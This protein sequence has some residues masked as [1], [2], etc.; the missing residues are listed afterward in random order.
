MP[1]RI[2]PI[3]PLLV[4]A[5]IVRVGTHQQRRCN[6]PAFFENAEGNMKIMQI[7]NNGPASVLVAVAL[8]RNAW[9]SQQVT[10]HYQNGRLIRADGIDLT[11]TGLNGLTGTLYIVKDS[12]CRDNRRV[13]RV[14]RQKI[15]DGEVVDRQNWGELEDA[16]LQAA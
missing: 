6:D 1:R 11:Q 4:T 14:E 3:G 2:A 15:V 16:G 9:T 8:G 5:V 10:L 13:M 7:E 12:L